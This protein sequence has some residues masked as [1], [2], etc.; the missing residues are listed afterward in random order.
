MLPHQLPGATATIL[1]LALLAGCGSAPPARDGAGESRSSGIVADRA[2]SYAQKF[3]GTRYRYGGNHPN[4]GFDCSGLVQYSYSLAG[5]KVP[6]STERQMQATRYVPT[7]QLKRG[8][9]LFFHQEGKRFSHVG[10][11]IG[12]GRFVH[13]PSSGKSVKISTLSNSYW[14]KHLASTRR[15]IY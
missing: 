8:D 4:K 15:F 13:A 6:R 7:N 9:L 10:I 12:R 11:Y 5:V 1:A 14:R 3:I 2:A